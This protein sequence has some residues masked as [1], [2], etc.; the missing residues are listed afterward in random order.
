MLKL[1]VNLIYGGVGTVTA[2]RELFVEGCNNTF[3]LGAMAMV[4]AIF[5]GHF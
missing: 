5:L 3:S 4:V 2:L 1:K